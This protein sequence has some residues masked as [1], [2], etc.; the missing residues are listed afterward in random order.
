MD[1]IQARKGHR[2]SI[3]DIPLGFSAMIQSSPQLMPISGQSTWNKFVPAENCLFGSVK[4]DLDRKFSDEVLSSSMNLDN[5]VT[6]ASSDSDIDNTYGYAFNSSSGRR[7]GVKRN[8]EGT[9]KHSR[10]VSMDSFLEN[11]NS[12]DED[13][14][15]KFSLEFG[16]GEFSGADLKK[17]IADNKLAEIAVID[18][19]RAKRCTN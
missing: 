2:R 11:F 6:L 19:K 13:N 18:P 1:A 9:M 15:T 3:S 5:V 16:N 4:Q 8:A 17:I 7:E 12:K 14:S 10:S